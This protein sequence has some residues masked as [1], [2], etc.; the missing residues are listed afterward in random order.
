MTTQAPSFIGFNHMLTD[1]MIIRSIKLI[2]ISYVT[3]IYV[4]MAILV[5]FIIDKIFNKFDAETAKTKTSTR[6]LLEI[7]LQFSMI[8][9]LLYIG[10]NIIELIP[11]PLNGVK[12]FDHYRIHE[13]NLLAYLIFGPMVITLQRGLMNKLYFVYQRFFEP[14]NKTS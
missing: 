10:R 8:A 3:T 14:T 6:L 9:I 2:D 4:V 1:E 12:G 13:I 5:S 11:F 7:I